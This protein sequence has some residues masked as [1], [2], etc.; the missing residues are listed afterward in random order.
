MTAYLLAFL[1]AALAT[2]EAVQTRREFRS[3][4]AKFDFWWTYPKL[5]AVRSED[6]IGFWLIVLA[7]VVASGILLYFASSLV[8]SA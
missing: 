1:S 4:Y 6:A 3:G 2:W 8:R 5:E 7:K